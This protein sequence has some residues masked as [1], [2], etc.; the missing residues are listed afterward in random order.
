MEWHL[1]DMMQIDRIAIQGPVASQ[2]FHSQS[3]LDCELEILDDTGDK[4]QDENINS[5]SSTY[6]NIPVGVTGQ[7]VY[8]RQKDGDRP[9]GVHGIAILGQNPNGGSGGTVD[10]NDVNDGS[11]TFTPSLSDQI[12]YVWCSAFSMPISVTSSKGC[13]YTI[14]AISTP[15]LT[16]SDGTSLDYFNTG[17]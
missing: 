6:Y 1:P 12:D 9:L 10:C 14:E 15:D 3:L 8:I 7:I 17:S 4:V 16:V 13:A 5:V 11:V 2:S